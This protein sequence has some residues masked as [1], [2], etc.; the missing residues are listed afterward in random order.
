VAAPGVRAIGYAQLSR[1]FAADQGFYKLQ[2]QGAIARGRPYTAVELQDLAKQYIAGMR[3]VQRE[4]PYYLAAMCDG[5]QIAEKMV[6]QLESQGHE[7]GLFAVFDTWVMEN[8]HRRWG[9]YVFNY[10]QRARWLRKAGIRESLAWI[11]SA[12]AS[13]IR[14]WTGKTR[15]STP[16]AE[17]YWPTNFQ[18]PRFR[19]PV[20]LFRRPKQPYYYVNDPLLG[21]GA[22]SEGGVEVHEVNAKHHEVLREPHVQMISR[23]IV[24]RMNRTVGRE[25]AP[26][27]STS[28][29]VA[30]ASA[31]VSN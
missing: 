1:H 27:L 5:C 29:Q 17:A 10:R 18:I 3:A 16:W 12:S 2:A 11:K 13:R 7:V 19:A 6:L 9:W 25:T 14:I 15:A 31:A 22:R 26:E 24:A 23:I 8:I 4:G 21:W 28:T 30:A 20:L